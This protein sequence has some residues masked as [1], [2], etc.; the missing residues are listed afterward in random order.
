MIDNIERMG[1]ALAGAFNSERLVYRAFQNNE[2]D[3]NWVFIHVESDPLTH[4]LGD[5]AVHKPQTRQASDATMEQRLKNSVLFVMICL[6]DKMQPI[7]TLNVSDA[8]GYQ[9]RARFGITMS[10]EYQSK[11]FGSEAINWLMDWAFRWGGYHSLTLGASLYNERAVSAYKKAGFTLE[12]ISRECVY[13][14]RKWHDTCQ[15]S[16]L[17]HEWEALRGIISDK[18]QPSRG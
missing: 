13:R 11:G 14:D 6:P 8:P 9:R 17:E 10:P 1:P 18:S 7:G 12:G 16:I 5:P 4:G 3:K 15:M 2:E